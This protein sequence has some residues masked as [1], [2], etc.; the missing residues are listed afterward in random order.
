MSTPPEQTKKFNEI[1]VICDE[2]SQVWH[3]SSQALAGLDHVRLPS[4]APIRASWDR[5]KNAAR[6]IIYWENKGRGG[7]A[8]VEE[9]LE[10]APLFDITDRII[11]LTTNPTHEDIVYLSELGLSRVVKLRMRDRDVESAKVEIIG[12]VNNT[13]TSNKVESAWLRIYRAL[14]FIPAD[15]AAPHLVKVK[16]AVTKLMAQSEGKPTA[17]YHDV[18]AAIARLEGR[19]D[20]ALYLWGKALELNPNYFRSYNNLIAFHHDRG[21][22]ES[23][24]GLMHKMNAMNNSRVSRIV[25]MGEIHAELG[26]DDKAEHCFTSALTK[27]SYCSAAMN[28]LAALRFKQG[29]LEESRHLLS[30]SAI[31]YKLAARLNK[32][33]IDMVRL[34]KFSDALEHYT[35]AQYVLPQQ[36]KGPMLFY[37][38]GLCYTRWGKPQVGEKFLRLALIKE[39]NYKKAQR[40]LDSIGQQGV[41]ELEP[42]AA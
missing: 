14:H 6:I 11:I 35:K 21:R 19:D 17:R 27:D 34:G 36:D 12:H 18:M 7:G 33:G 32:Q 3:L 8:I 20:E 5:F 23:A 31:A 22:H 38:I 25:L 24:L 2:Q 28:G 29:N 13:F 15:N 37:N 9:I 42:A 40:L 10:I 30:Q 4:T 41:V 39:P 26:E 1:L 16:S